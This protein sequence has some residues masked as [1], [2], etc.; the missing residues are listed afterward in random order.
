[1]ERCGCRGAIYYDG[2]VRFLVY[3]AFECCSEKLT[4]IFVLQGNVA[5]CRYHSK[6][7]ALR[8]SFFLGVLKSTIPLIIT[9]TAEM[10]AME[11]GIFG[12]RYSASA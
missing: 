5:Q 4:L 10:K 1:M 3:R 2:Y 12:E 11:E 9:F 6:H 7:L 8:Q